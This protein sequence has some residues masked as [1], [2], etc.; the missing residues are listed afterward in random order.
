MT[1]FIITLEPAPSPDY[2]VRGQTHPTLAS[3][4]AASQYDGA[5]STLSASSWTEKSRQSKSGG[6]FNSTAQEQESPA[7]IVELSQ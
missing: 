4:R 7:W 5:W 6:I 3:A 1:I 2:I